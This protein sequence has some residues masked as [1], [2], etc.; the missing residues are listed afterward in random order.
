MTDAEVKSKKEGMTQEWVLVVR[1]FRTS[2]HQGDQTERSLSTVRAQQQ[3]KQR[4]RWLAMSTGRRLH[5][6]DLACSVIVLRACSECNTLRSSTRWNNLLWD[7]E[8]CLQGSK[9]GQ[10]HLPML[11]K[12]RGS[13]VCVFPSE[14]QPL[15]LLTR[16][17]GSHSSVYGEVSVIS[18]ARF[19]LSCTPRTGPF[20][21]LASSPRNQARWR[22]NSCEGRTGQ[23]PK[24]STEGPEIPF[25]K[26]T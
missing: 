11:R 14:G 3:E 6:T 13:T 25:T 4:Q 16:S 10:R 22:V 26:E 17:Q 8:P 20:H 1:R 24:D 12:W 18:P 2:S 19:P 21:S 15:T 23:N 5:W 9:T 7:I